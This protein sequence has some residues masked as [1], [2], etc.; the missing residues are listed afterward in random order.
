MRKSESYHK[1]IREH[2]EDAKE[3]ATF[4][5]V[6]A[7]FS[8]ILN[9]DG[10]VEGEIRFVRPTGYSARSL[11]I[12]VES[13][14]K[15]PK[16]VWISVG[17]RFEP[18][19]RIE[20]HIRDPKRGSYYMVQGMISLASYGQRGRQKA[21]NFLEARHASEVME[22]R[23]QRKT[24]EVFVRFRWDPEDKKMP[25]K[26]KRIEKKLRKRKRVSKGSSKPKARVSR[27]NK[28]KSKGKTNV[29]S[30]R[31]K[32]QGNKRR[33]KAPIHRKSKAKPHKRKPRAKPR[34]SRRR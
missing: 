2:F 25:H 14:V 31:R 28:P 9:P 18:T 24:A 13:W 32:R 33:V 6:D 22:D 20:E 3:K 8:T 1:I 27:K 5:G 21:A 17:S 29:I 16:S 26:G 15:V 11:L 4:N 19:S 30:R 7:H 12:D 10:S 34:R 23:T